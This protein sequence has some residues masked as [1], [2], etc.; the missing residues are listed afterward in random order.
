MMLIDLNVPAHDQRIASY[1]PAG[2]Q[3]AR[4]G[5]A[6]PSTALKLARFWLRDANEVNDPP[7]PHTT[8]H[9]DAQHTHT[10]NSASHGSVCQTAFLIICTANDFRLI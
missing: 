4:V 7:H 3:P 10:T 8:Q 2:P 1:G 9:H 5:P 6:E